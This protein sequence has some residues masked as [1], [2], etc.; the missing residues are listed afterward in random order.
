MDTD[1]YGLD[2]TK[3]KLRSEIR[4]VLNNLPP[5][6]RAADSAKVRALLP[7]QS[8]WEAAAAILLFAPLPNEVDIWP[9][10]EEA[11]A[12]ERIVALPRF[13]AAT[14]KYTASH[15]QN[16]QSEIVTGR[17][18]IREPV[19]N[20]VEIPLNRFDLVLAPG[21]AF[22]A[23]GHRLGRGRG[24]FDRLLAEVRGVKCGVAFDEQIVNAVP[25]GML[26]VRMNFVLTPT[27]CVTCDE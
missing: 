16:P 26:D 7:Q 25:A 22:D 20:C 24:F 18:G 13:N 19:A 14:G 9:L 6:K 10:L 12:T 3:V 1:K 15:V 21:V 8:F 23:L 2:K 27:R 4:G 11:A 5:K 17:F